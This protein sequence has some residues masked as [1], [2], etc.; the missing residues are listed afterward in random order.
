M[1]ATDFWAQLQTPTPMDRAD[2]ASK[3]KTPVNGVPA[4]AAATAT[5]TAAS[6]SSI[7]LQSSVSFVEVEKNGLSVKFINFTC[8]PQY[9]GTSPE[10]Q[11][12]ADQFPLVS[13]S[14]RTTV[15]TLQLKKRNLEQ[16]MRLQM[17]RALFGMNV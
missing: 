15:A 5:A 3:D 14:Y 2:G 11:R 12:L 8:M 6:S 10:E 13:Q 7:P 4:A 17:S 1:A 16:Q 9:L